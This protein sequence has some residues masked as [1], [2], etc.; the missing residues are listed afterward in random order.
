[1]GLGQDNTCAVLEGGALYCW[2]NGFYGQLGLSTYSTIGDNELPTS[3][4]A[5]KLGIGAQTIATSTFSTCAV[6]ADKNVRCWGSTAVGRPGNPA[7]NALE[8]LGDD[9]HPDQASYNA[10]LG[11]EVTQVSVGACHACAVMTTGKLQCWGC[12][13]A[14]QLGRGNTDILGDNETPASAGFLDLGNRIALKV[15]AF[16]QSTCVLLDGGEVRCWGEGGNGEL[17]YGNKKTLGDDPD[18]LPSMLPPVPVGTLPQDAVLQLDAGYDHVCAVL[19]GGRLRC[20]GNHLYGKLGYKILTPIGDNEPASA[21]GDVPVGAVVKQVS[22]GDQHTCALLDTGNIR[23]WGIYLGGRLGYPAKQNIGDDE[24]PS[25]GEDVFLP[26]GEGPAP[27]LLPSVSN[28]RWSRRRR[29][30]R[31]R[32]SSRWTSWTSRCSP[33]SCSTS[34]CSPRSCWTSRRRCRRRWGRT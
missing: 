33:R 5:V 19:Q 30:T 29:R 20:W 14:G 15:V 31:R 17:G 4:G 22:V 10:A 34:R 8:Y 28:R 21:M 27:R 7:L 1:M 2:G 32:P 26:P 18:E 24:F 16:Q 25:E 11:G 6:L 3:E 13:A 12:N 9:E 23:C